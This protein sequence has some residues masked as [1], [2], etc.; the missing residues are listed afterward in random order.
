MA[1]P[2]K[3]RKVGFFPDDNYFIPFGK[4]RCEVK[5]IVLKVEELEAIRLKDM[6]G[7]NQEECAQKMQISR[8]TFQNIIDSARKKIAE[9]LVQGMALRI[10]GGNY[11]TDSCRFK[12]RDC[13]NIYEV[14]YEN[15]RCIC[16]KCGS[17]KVACSKKADFCKK[18]CSCRL[19]R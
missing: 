17:K 5:E 10:K 2:I 3:C 13:G 11:T 6:E 8:Q 7:L 12:C 15:D 16:P 19:K 1:R 4:K 9:A 14:K 18:W